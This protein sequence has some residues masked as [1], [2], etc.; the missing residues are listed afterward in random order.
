M[1]APRDIYSEWLVTF[2]IFTC[3][4]R[5]SVILLHACGSDKPSERQVLCHLEGIH[6]MPRDM[7]IYE[8]FSVIAFASETRIRHNKT[9]LAA[10]MFY[11]KMLL[12]PML[13]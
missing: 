13:W 9:L 4:Q 2:L 3:M 8:F 12:F 7:D 10:A 5:G 6:Q 11:I 1:P